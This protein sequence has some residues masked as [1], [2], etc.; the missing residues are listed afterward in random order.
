MCTLDDYLTA[1]ANE[2]REQLEALNATWRRKFTQSKLDL[3][4]EH[5]ATAQA[6]KHEHSLAQQALQQAALARWVAL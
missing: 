5:N 1:D 4:H 2:L 3:R 6:I